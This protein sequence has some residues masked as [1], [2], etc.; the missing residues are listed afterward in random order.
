[1]SDGNG[2][3]AYPEC[4][5]HPKFTIK[6]LPEGE[7]PRERLL[8]NGVQA[9][10][11]AELLAIILR[12]GTKKENVVDLAKH[13]LVDRDLKSMS[14]LSAGDLIK[15][16]GIG[17]AK[18]CQIIAAFELGRRVASNGNGE[19]PAM[20]N[21]QAVA[22]YFM[23]KLQILKQET[24]YCAYLNT[25]NRMIREQLISVGGLN[26]SIV[27]PRDVF[28]GAMSEGAASIILVHNHPSG[29]PAPSRDDIEVTRKLMSAGDVV[30]IKVLDHVVIGEGKWVSLKEEGGI[31]K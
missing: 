16:F 27:E 17:E 19:K 28:R 6:E 10:S 31:W 26:A 13:L 15:M 29:D 30:G 12:T 11:N 9:L 8:N 25:K 18:A 21:P 1:M 24:F 5:V 7:R 2:I 3:K 20:K 22:E 14:Q 23:P 4:E